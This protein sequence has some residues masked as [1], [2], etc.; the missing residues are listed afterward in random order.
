MVGFAE[1][2]HV[3]AGHPV[4]QHPLYLKHNMKTMGDIAGSFKNIIKSEIAA[5]IPTND[6]MAI[7]WYLQNLLDLITKME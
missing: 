4:L 3:P 7:L 1:Y 5:M 2:F 6:N